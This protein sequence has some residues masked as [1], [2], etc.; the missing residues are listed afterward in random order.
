MLRLLDESQL[1]NPEI[2]RTTIEKGRMRGQPILIFYWSESISEL[3][4]KD[5]VQ[6]TVR[7]IIIDE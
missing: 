5:L 1:E 7:T 4:A 6:R 3:D 2:E